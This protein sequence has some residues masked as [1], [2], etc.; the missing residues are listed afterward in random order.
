V[1]FRPHGRLASVEE[2]P[3]D[4][5]SSGVSSD[6]EEPDRATAANGNSGELSVTDGQLCSSFASESRSETLLFDH[7]LKIVRSVVGAAAEESERRE[8]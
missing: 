2:P 5:F 3:A 7:R 6:E 8:V 4:P 1:T